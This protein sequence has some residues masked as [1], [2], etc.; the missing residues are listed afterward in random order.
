MKTPV[1]IPPGEMEAAAGRA[2]EFLKT[3]SNEARLRILCALAPGE[4]SVS[5]LCAELAMRQAAV[6]QQLQRLRAE[7]MVRTRRQGK[8]VYYKIDSHEVRTL[9]NV[10]REIFD[11]G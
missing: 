2:S 11:Q 6:S 3:L 4:K 10:L 7:Q 5:A 9:L 8:E 1:K